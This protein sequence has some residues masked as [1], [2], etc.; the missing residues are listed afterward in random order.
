[1]AAQLAAAVERALQVG[2]GHAVEA[3]TGRRLAGVTHCGDELRET[4]ERDDLA[5]PLFQILADDRGDAG[6]DVTRP[7]IRLLLEDTAD[8]V[9]GNPRDEQNEQDG[10]AGSGKEKA[11]P[12]LLRLG[13]HGLSF[14][15]HERRPKLRS[16]YARS[17]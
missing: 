4:G 6:T 1:I 3:A 11:L 5:S 10:G 9:A 17:K 13:R 15:T 2:D 12:Q 16:R 7:Q 14:G 8:A